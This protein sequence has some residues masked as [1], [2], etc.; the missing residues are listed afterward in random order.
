MKRSAEGVTV[1]SGRG[2]SARATPATN[3]S[4][5]ERRMAE[6]DSSVGALSSERAPIIVV[7][8]R[9]LA[10]FLAL[11][12]AALANPSPPRAPRV[13]HPRSLHGVTLDDDWFWLREKRSKRVIEYLRAEARYAEQVMRPTAPLRETLYRE[14]RARIAPDYTSAPYRIGNHYYY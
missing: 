2:A 7:G 11:S 3:K 9:A 13:P 4:A 14:M 5:R 10:V 8:V 12:T 1:T 6:A